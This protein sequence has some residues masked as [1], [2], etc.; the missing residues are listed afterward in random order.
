MIAFI[1]VRISWLVAARNAL[2]A[3]FACSATSRASRASRNSRAFSIAMAA[4]W[5]SPTRKFRS[6]SG[7]GSVRG[8]RQT[9]IIPITPPRARSGEGGHLRRPA[10]GLAVQP[11]VRDGHPDVGRDRGEQPGVVLPE[12]PG[13][14]RALDADH[15][16]GPRLDRDRHAEVGERG[17]PDDLHALERL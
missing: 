5:D 1:G 9:A 13:L 7:K 8:P 11:G 16:D 3:A 17:R 12:P 4:C 15:A 14:L 6:A 2:F 10:P